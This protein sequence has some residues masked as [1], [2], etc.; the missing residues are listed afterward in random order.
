MDLRDKLLESFESEDDL[1]IVVRTHIVIENYLRE[2]VCSFLANEK[3]FENA[4]LEYSQVVQLSLAV[5][6]QPRF[7]SILK[8]IGKLRN[9]FAHKYRDSLNKNDVKNL[10][11]ALSK[12]EKENLQKTTKKVAEELDLD[13][14]KHSDF[15]VRQQFIN[16]SVMLAAVLQKACKEASE[17]A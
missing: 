8:A 14:Y 16:I 10:Y 4:K 9:N 13:P 1:A 5:G 6:L 3:Y 15:D 12:D 11:N 17:R 2:L 7:E